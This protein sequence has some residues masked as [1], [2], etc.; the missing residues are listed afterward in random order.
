MRHLSARPRAHGS[1]PR[2]WGDNP[3]DCEAT[4]PA[5]R[6]CWCCVAFSRGRGCCRCRV[7]FPESR[8]DQAADG[9]RAARKSDCL[10][11]HWSKAPINSGGKRTP[12]TGFVP[13]A[14]LPR[15][16]FVDTQKNGPSKSANSYSGLT[17]AGVSSCPR[18]SRLYQRS[19]TSV[20]A[21]HRRYATSR[22]KWIPASAPLP[23]KWSGAA[24]RVFRSVLI[25]KRSSAPLTVLASKGPWARGGLP[26]YWNGRSARCQ[27]NGPHRR[28]PAGSLGRAPRWNAAR[29]KASSMT[30]LG[31][32]RI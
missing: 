5:R 4:S 2:G 28:R 20:P 19:T 15:R 18:L 8:L 6:S 16:C 9:F 23:A 21:S 12:V 11:R 13:V 22:L 1:Q 31:L 3:Y 7:W 25:G 29:S 27:D 14:G 32:S 26:A 24:F 17:S 10:R 30:P